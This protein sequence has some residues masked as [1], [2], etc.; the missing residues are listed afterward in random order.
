M[1]KI[2][3]QITTFLLEIAMLAS[4][5]YY[6]MSR[7]WNLLPRLLLGIGLI[8]IAISLWAV[9]AAPKSGKRLR[10]PYLVIFRACMF[11]LASILLFMSGQKSYAILFVVLAIVSQTVSYFTEK[12]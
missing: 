12:E 11:I 4:L 5:G 1:L 8:G 3:N 10:M 7:S 9:F 2:I 6:G